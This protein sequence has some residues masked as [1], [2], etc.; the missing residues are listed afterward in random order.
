MPDIHCKTTARHTTP[1]VN[2]VAAASMLAKVTRT[3]LIELIPQA[4]GLQS[5]TRNMHEQSQ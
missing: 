4:D 5:N 2:N 1:S 3:L